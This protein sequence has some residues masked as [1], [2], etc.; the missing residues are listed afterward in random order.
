MRNATSKINTNLG[1][2]WAVSYNKSM[3]FRRDNNP[4]SQF[5]TYSTVS[6]TFDNDLSRSLI[7]IGADIYIDTDV[8]TPSLL[9]KSRAIIALKN[10]KW[11]WGNIWIK[12]SVKKIESVLFS[13]KSILS[14]EEFITGSLSPYY[15]TKKSVFV[16]IP[17]NQLYIKWS[18]WGYNTIWGSSKSGWAVCPYLSDSS[19][20]CSYDNAIKYDWN[21]FRI[22]NG[23][24]ARRA[25]KNDSKDDYS[26]I[27]EYDPRT[28]QDPPPGLETLQ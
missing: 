20:L 2:A 21:Y 27:I 3:I 13:E 7:V 4:S 28:I 23:A 26:V 5:L 11:E 9:N 14:G 17:R 24:P 18:I 19:T 16:D 8:I 22:Y 12:W 25:Y 10:E 15:V 6:L 1:G